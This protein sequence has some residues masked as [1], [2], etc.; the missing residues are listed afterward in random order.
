M[1]TFLSGQKECIFWEPDIVADAKAKLAVLS[2]KGRQLG[3]TSIHIVALKEG[4]SAWNIDI[5]QVL[6][7][8]SG[9][10]LAFFVETQA[11]VEDASVI[12]DQFWDA[13][14]DDVCLGL[15]GHL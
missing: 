2:L 15:T 7:A 12:L 5:E 6:L 9:S 1:D 4:N 13:T 3:R 10:N 8:M 11:S 14:T